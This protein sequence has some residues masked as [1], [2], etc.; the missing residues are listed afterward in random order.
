MTF[1]QSARAAFIG[2][3]RTSLQKRLGEKTTFL[4]LYFF[5][6]LRKFIIL[7]NPFS[8]T[9]NDFQRFDTLNGGIVGTL[10]IVS[11]YQNAIRTYVQ[12]IKPQWKREEKMGFIGRT[13]RTIWMGLPSLHPTYNN[14]VFIVQTHWA[15]TSLHIYRDNRTWGIMTSVW[16]KHIF[17]SFVCLTFK[18]YP[19]RVSNFPPPPWR[20]DSLGLTLAVDSK[21]ECTYSLERYDN[22]LYQ[23]ELLK[24]G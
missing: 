21:R 18:I 23:S 2:K 14:S 11:A 6:F 1:F 24:Q 15:D 4:V 5:H 12:W 19:F 9:K 20:T 3:K 17:P 16:R 7:T 10:P 8:V 13:K 22:C